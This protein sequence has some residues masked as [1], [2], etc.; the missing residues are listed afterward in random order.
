ME[1]SMRR[2]F[3][4]PTVRVRIER[5]IFTMSGRSAT[6]R[7]KLERPRPKS[8]MAMAAPNAR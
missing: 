5:S 7:S 1:G 4:S 8:S 3:A 6:M 2:D